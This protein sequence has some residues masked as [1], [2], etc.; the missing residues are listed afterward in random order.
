MG[1]RAFRFARIA[2]YT[3]LGHDVCVRVAGGRT[4]S[5]LVSFSPQFSAHD[6]ATQYADGKFDNYGGVAVGAAFIRA[7]LLP[8]PSEAFVQSQNANYFYHKQGDKAA[9]IA[10]LTPDTRY[11]T[12]IMGGCDQFAGN[13]DVFAHCCQ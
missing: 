13:A 1:L 12:Y 11:A 2:D 7:G 5:N 3:V 4:L 10:G 8:G 6:L 9:I